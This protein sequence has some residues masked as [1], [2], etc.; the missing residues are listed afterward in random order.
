[1]KRIVSLDYLRILSCV[2]VIGIHGIWLLSPEDN[3]ESSLILYTVMNHIVRLGLPLFFILSSVA[4]AKPIDLLSNSNFA[5]SFCLCTLKIQHLTGIQS[6]K[7]PLFRPYAARSCVFN[8][9]GNVSINAST[10][11]LIVSS[12]SS[13]L[14]LSMA[15]NI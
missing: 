14:S 11:S 12:V 15:R 2:L 1:M 3:S 13:V 8:K 10:N 5:H 7:L 6:L 9:T 4:L